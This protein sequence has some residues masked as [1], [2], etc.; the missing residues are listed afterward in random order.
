MDYLSFFY[1]GPE[2]A[3][4]G[5]CGQ[6]ESSKAFSERTRRMQMPIKLSMKMTC[7]SQIK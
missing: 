5:W 4:L 6:D 1:S 2:P 7:Q 3:I